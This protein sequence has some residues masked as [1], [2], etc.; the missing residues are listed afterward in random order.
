MK[1]MIKANGFPSLYGY[2][3]GYGEETNGGKVYIKLTPFCNGIEVKGGGE[4]SQFYYWDY[5]RPALAAKPFRHGRL[6]FDRL[7]SAPYKPMDSPH[8]IQ[9]WSGNQHKARPSHYQPQRYP[10]LHRPKLQN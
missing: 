5:E 8:D 3:C 1:R 9:E 4:W 10:S 7:T 6:H 2:A